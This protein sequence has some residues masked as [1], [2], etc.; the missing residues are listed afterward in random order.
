[1]LSIIAM[2]IAAGA[3]EATLLPRVDID[4]R[5]D[6]A[7]GVMNGEA[8]IFLAPS[9]RRD[10]FLEGL[11]VE[12]I[13]IDGQEIDTEK[14][15]GAYLVND[16]ALNLPPVEKAREIRIVYR[17][18]PRPGELLSPQQIYLHGP[19]HPD[20]GGEAIFALT[21]NLPPGFHGISQAEEIVEEETAD[22]V[23]ARF[24]FPHPQRG[25]DL[26]AGPYLISRA[27]IENGP[28][29]YAYFFPEDRDLVQDYLERGS[30][31]IRRY[32]EL[33]GPF[34][35]K[36]FSIVENR[37]P[38]GF[39]MPT[40]TLLGQM[41]VRLP[42]ITATSLG[43]EILHQWFGNSVAV[44]DESGNWCEG[45]ATYL[46]DQSYAVDRGE[47][48]QFRKDQILRYESFVH[49]ANA[50]SLEEFLGGV[51]HLVRG[52]DASRAVGYGKASM[53]FHMLRK[54]IGDPAFYEGLR[55][56]YQRFKNRPAQW[57]DLE[58]VF[59][60]TSKEQLDAFFAGWLGSRDI[61]CLSVSG[62]TVSEK[63]GK[64]NLSFDLVQK[65]QKPKVLRVPCRVITPGGNLD[66]TIDLN[67]EKARVS[68]DLD[69][70]PEAVVIDPEYDLMRHL[71]R[72]ELTPVWSRVSGAE[73]RIFVLKDKETEEK[74]A[75]LLN[76][77]RTEK[78]ETLLDSEAD[79]RKLETADVVFIDA[80][81]ARARSIFAG[82]GSAP[83]KGFRL[84][85]RANPLNP[86]RTATLVAASTADE[87]AAATRK[88]KHYGKYS[89]L[90][91]TGGRIKTREVS[92]SAM[93]IRYQAA[94]EPRAIESRPVISFS[95]VMEKIAD[96]KVVYVGESHTSP[97]DH[98]L[99]IRVVR[100]MYAQDP[101]LAIGM[102]MFSHEAQ[103]AL[104]RYIIKKEIDE[105]AFL[106]ECKY[107]SRWGYDFR[108][109][110]P[111][112]DF[113][114]EK[115]IP[116]IALNQP[117]TTVSKVFGNGGLA[118][119]SDEEAA[120]LPPERDLTLPGYRE[121]LNRV[122][123]MHRIKG[124]LND[125]LQAQ[126]I[127]DETMAATA[128][129]YLTENPTMRMVILAGRGHVEPNAIPPRVARRINAPQAVLLND[130]PS[131]NAAASAD[132]VLFT[133][134][135]PLPPLPLMGVVLQKEKDGVRIVKVNKKSPA[136]HAG[137]KKNDLILAADGEKVTDIGDIK[138]LM[139]YK[140]RGSTITLL[141]RRRHLLWPTTTGEIKIKL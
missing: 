38:T 76:A 3:G 84:E 127:W 122:F 49:P 81:G 42:F 52:Q 71:D 31:Y 102:E 140:K 28:D 103:K 30:Q 8:R 111:I 100:A 25:I 114:R 18:H 44:A 107:F 109:Y 121:R 22:G 33:I 54:R 82:S 21:A 35:Y 135:K 73:K 105:P 85:V 65:G 136:W 5:F 138:V 32:Q 112:L 6:L 88:L 69:D 47:G 7:A 75:A 131:G 108:F 98:H 124:S 83:E 60:E 13:Y 24:S 118:A 99:Q 51:S 77:L 36:R 116:V 87:V 80:T 128:A 39:A 90:E 43:H 106:K 10:I 50:I 110:R 12:K 17:Y 91:F 119:L 115:G 141:V 96:R 19:W 56:F 89:L 37:L 34:P 9:V 113:A 93:G 64:V 58:K 129:D 14:N 46:A 55:L 117:K 133:R 63:G 16:Q 74:Y 27:E 120:A 23:V 40:F 53:L 41:V 62:L 132:F 79:D 48:P 104:D 2:P 95:Q 11:D 70:Y 101:Q 59:S 26:V 126:T 67:N 78:D 137:V 94:P 97:A 66:R 123:H 86:G 29:L 68:L 61:P 1:M 130:D 57:S 72:S 125:F 20:L 92:P 15:N 4:A 139:L 134:T 45:L